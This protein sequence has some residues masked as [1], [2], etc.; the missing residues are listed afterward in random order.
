V[1]EALSELAAKAGP[2]VVAMNLQALDLGLE[3]GAPIP[4]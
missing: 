1:R 3:R 4:A 2:A